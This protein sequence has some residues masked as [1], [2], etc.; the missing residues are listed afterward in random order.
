M[1]L[2]PVGFTLSRSPDRTRFQLPLNDSRHSRPPASVLH[3]AMAVVGVEMSGS[4]WLV[5]LTG[6]SATAR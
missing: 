2:L 6:I 1:S 4:A 5:V 3:L